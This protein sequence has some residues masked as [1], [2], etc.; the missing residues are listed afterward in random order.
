MDIEDFEF[1][2]DGCQIS[3]TN[4][5][6]ISFEPY[7]LKDKS[8]VD[9]I[10]KEN[11]LE[12]ISP[13]DFS[14]LAKELF[15]LYQT[16]KKLKQKQI[17]DFSKFTPKQVS[18]LPL[19]EKVKYLELLFP[20]NQTKK[21]LME[22]CENNKDNL[23]ACL[24]NMD[25]PKN[26]WKK[27]KQQADRFVN[28]V[29]GSSEIIGKIENW[30]NS[31]LE[32]KKEAI[33]QAAEIFKYVYGDAPKIEFFTEQQERERLKNLGLPDDVH[34]NGADSSNGVIR[35][36]EDRLQNSDNF[37]G[38]SVLFHEGTHF[39]QDTT[40]FEDPIVN[41]IFAL[42]VNYLNAYENMLNDKNSSDYK[43]FYTMQ[44]A[45]THAYGLQEYMENNLIEKTGIQ[46]N[47]NED[48]QE[49]KKIH[50]KGFSMAKLTQY[51]SNRNTR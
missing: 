34:I 25:F 40:S 6:K 23:R 48:T 27:E 24:F 47:C 45:E 44:P 18:K 4:D 19:G 31:S 13:A 10:L 16:R 3:V 20:S 29:A 22:L 46:K 33:K 36:N 11:E 38:V 2:V 39:R 12:N 1:L 41:R 15:P 8:N 42:N 30:K 50:N 32:D 21:N 14:N 35:F 5:D 9:K 28:L 49:T 7:R 37:F 17:E 43:D 26:F 51:R